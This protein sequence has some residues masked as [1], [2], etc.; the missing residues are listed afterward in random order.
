MIFN[1]KKEPYGINF[2][3]SGKE[4]KIQNIN[5]ALHT[6]KG[7]MPLHREFG[8]FPP[9]ADPVSPETESI[10][11]GEVT[12]VLLDNI[13]D[14]EVGEV[15]FDYDKEEGQLVFPSVEVELLDG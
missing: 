10:I 13:D 1:T 8:W 6:V 3:A 12:E 5:F 9:I 7:T 2:G 15:F 14:I 11:A 4:A